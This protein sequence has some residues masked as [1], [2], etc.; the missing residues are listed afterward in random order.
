MSEDT[1]EVV[2]HAIT[3][4]RI[5]ARYGEQGSRFADLF[6]ASYPH[7]LNKAGCEERDVGGN[8]PRVPP[9]EGIA[10][11]RIRPKAPS[12]FSQR[13]EEKMRAAGEE[14]RLTRLN[15]DPQQALGGGSRCASPV[16][17]D[18]YFRPR[19]QIPDSLEQRNFIEKTASASSATSSTASH[20][21]CGGSSR[22]SRTSDETG[23]E[24]EHV[25]VKS[26]PEDVSQLANVV[27][28]SF[29]PVSL[30]QKLQSHRLLQQPVARQDCF[31]GAAELER[32]FAS[33]VVAPAKKPIIA[34]HP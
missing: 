2:Q 18:S 1:D 16:I 31:R 34:P 29:H 13:V 9:V 17:G 8:T 3:S 10:S 7:S 5:D 30:H 11:S 33:S 24:D 28:S 25:K 20:C 19:E 4:A 21:T 12:S 23:Y 6:Y 22:S 27:V 26:T 32:Q 15:T 14:N